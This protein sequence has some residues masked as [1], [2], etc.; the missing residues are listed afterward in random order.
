M[1][2]VNMAKVI[3]TQGTQEKY[4]Y[5]GPYANE[6]EGAFYENV[7]C[8]YDVAREVIYFNFK[9]SLDVVMAKDK[10]IEFSIAT[11]MVSIK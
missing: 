2:A 8:G 9:N 5:G 3:S 1:G 11:G 10:T 6:S 4:K 7:S